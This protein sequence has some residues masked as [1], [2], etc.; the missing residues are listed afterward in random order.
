MVLTSFMSNKKWLLKEPFPNSFAE[1]FPAYNGIILSLLYSRGLDTQDKIDQFLGP[2]YSRDIHD[3]FLFKDMQK[4]CEII[5]D[6]IEKQKKILIYGDYDADGTTASA[7]LFNSLKKLGTENVDVFIPQRERDGYGLNIKNVEQFIADKIDLLITVDCGITNFAEVEKLKKAGVKVIITDHHMEPK[8]LPPADAILNCSLKREK[9]PFK[10][11]AGVGM[12]FKLAQGLF[13]SQK[14]PE[15]FEAFEKWLLDLVTIGTIGDISPILGENRVLVKYGLM[16]LNKTHR[17]G[18][19]ELIRVASLSNGQDLN[20]EVPVG[21]E[22]YDLSVRKVAFQ[23]VPRINSTGRLDD[24]NVSYKLLTTSDEIEAIALARDIQEKNLERQKLAEEMLIEA[25]EKFGKVNDKQ[26]ILIASSQ[27]WLPGMV[28]LAAGKLKDKYARPVILFSQNGEEFTGSGR[29]ILEFNI[30]ESANECSELT[31]KCGGHSQACGLTIVGSENFDKFVKAMNKIANK[32]LKNVELISSLEI[33]AEANLSDLNWEL[34]DELEKFE[35]FAE[36]NP[37]PLFCLRKVKIKSIEIIG[38][39]NNSLRFYIE[40]DGLTKKAISFFT[41][42]DWYDKIKAGDVVDLV[43]EFGVNEW[44][45]N[46][47]LQF[48]IIDFKLISK[49]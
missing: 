41:A 24:A 8:K 26:K 22:L 23:L 18:L 48:K 10:K 45:G 31:K 46:R 6:A 7:V 34:W 27:N 43:I 11:L 12:A 9:Y 13:K 3:P 30:T 42:E 20:E 35:P 29:S 44:N 47:E 49:S 17:K 14:N 36:A 25:E 37:M 1:N 40:Q 38:K 21:E 33:D 19:R 15:K 5:L 28:G 4:A 39:N 2:D 32:K 16:V